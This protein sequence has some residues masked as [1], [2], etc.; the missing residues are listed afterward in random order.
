VIPTAL[1]FSFSLSLHL[2]RWTFL[3]IRTMERYFYQECSCSKSFT[4]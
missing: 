2:F 4:I 3:D 1:R